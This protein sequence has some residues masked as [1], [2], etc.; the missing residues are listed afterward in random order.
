MVPVY[1]IWSVCYQK[2]KPNHARTGL[3]LD[4]ANGVQYFLLFW[5]LIKIMDAR[6]P[7][8]DSLMLMPSYA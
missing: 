4:Q 7:T 3:V 5:Y 1:G 2:E 8:L 6:M